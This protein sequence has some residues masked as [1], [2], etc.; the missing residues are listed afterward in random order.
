MDPC[1][2]FGP[3]GPGAV[4]I[5]SAISSSDDV[6]EGGLPDSAEDFS[7]AGFLGFFFFL[8]MVLLR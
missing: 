3:F 7:G 8:G 6:P 2:S 5:G 4:E 1:I